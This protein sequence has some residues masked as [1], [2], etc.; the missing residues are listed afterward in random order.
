VYAIAVKK[1]ARTINPIVS[2][3]AI[4]TGT[5][6]V[7]FALFLAYGQPQRLFSSPWWIQSLLILSGLLGIAGSHTLFF[8]SVKILGVAVSSS[9]TL[10]Q[11]LLTAI[12]SYV[13][14]SEILTPLQM[15][16]GLFI[17]VG[18]LLVIRT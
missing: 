2:F 6:V 8:Y 17:I 5:T 7:F 1:I 11:P 14:F 18:A 9:F 15:L 13:V 16:S 12:A 4:A 3:T 10:A